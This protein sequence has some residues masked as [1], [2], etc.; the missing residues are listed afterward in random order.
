MVAETGSTN[1]DL[2]TR[3]ASGEALPEGFWLIADRQTAGR[4]RQGR[5][6]LDAP[7]NFMGSTLVRLSP[8][9]PPAASLSFVTALAVYAC[10]SGQI[11]APASL[12]L[13]WPNDVLLAGRKFCGILLEREGPFAVIGVGVNLAAAPPLADRS[14]LALAERGARPDRDLFAADLAA[15]FAIELARWRKQGTGPMFSRWQAA[16]H[17]PG[18]RLS[19]HDGAGTRVAGTYDGLEPDGAL[20]LVR[21]DG[22]LARIHA[23]DVSH[24]G[25]D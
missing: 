16:A 25:S 1:A 7:G 24:E 5:P 17:P 2:L 3:L 4:G 23:G 12:Q 20:R 6:W 11:A 10:V 22:T 15:R 9:D 21:D 18:T 13:K 8:D 14:T 19:V